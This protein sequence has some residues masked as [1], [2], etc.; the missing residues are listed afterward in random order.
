[1]REK[2]GASA[3]KVSCPRG[4]PVSFVKQQGTESLKLFEMLKVA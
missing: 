2:I 4:R 1:M 3:L